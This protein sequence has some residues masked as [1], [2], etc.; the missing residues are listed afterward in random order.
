M[1]TK[2]DRIEDD[3]MN[4]PDLQDHCRKLML[5]L[6]LA[7]FAV[8]AQAGE[9][10]PKPASAATIAAQTQAR[11]T[12]PEDSR[13]D[14]E[15]VQRGFIATPAERE[16]RRADGH[17]V[18]H[19]GSLE[20]VKGDAPPS[21]NPSLW[22]QAKLLGSHGLYKVTEGVW[23]VRGID[24]ANMMIVSG[25]TGWI[26]IDPLM[27]TETASVAMK[28]VNE[29]LGQRPVSAVIYG[30]SHPDH[31]GGVRAVITPGTHP[32]IYAPEHLITEAVAENVIAGNAMARR[33]GYQFGISLKAGP[34]GYVNSGIV[35]A[36]ANG[37]TVTIIPP[38]DSIKA[39]GE[40][41]VIDG[42]NF[43]FQVVPETEAPSEM[44]FYLPQLNT[45]YVSEDT[46]CTMHNV[47]TPRGALVRD[48]NKW[49]WYITE[50]LNLYGDRVENLVTGHCWPRFGND[51]I[52]NYLALQRD[53]Y[54]F[55]HDQT[56]RLM[57]RGETPTEIAE[58][59]KVPAAISNQWSNHG[60]YGTVKHNAKGVFQR[61]IGW[62]DGIPAHLDQ[63]PTTELST[64]YVKAMGGAQ[65]VLREA[66]AAMK[67]GEYRWAA[68]ILS[69]LVFAAPDNKQAKAL[70]AD[71]YEQ[72]GYQQESAI[73]RNIYLTGADEL[74]GTA[75]SHMALASPDMVDAMPASAFLDLIATRLNPA[76]IGTRTMT[77]VVDYG[78][79]GDT[80]LVTLRNAVLVS[81]VGKSI[82]APTVSVSGPRM[83]L[84]GLFVRKLPLDKMETAGLKV[85]GDKAALQVL[86]DAIEP[87]PTDYLIVTP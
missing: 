1:A 78:G 67:R 30:H 17:V 32:P 10:A 81:E 33:T 34:R 63:L 37:G 56:V 76:R 68:Q 16:I 11:M 41:R 54:K 18:W 12:L 13:Q 22:R 86:L 65:G 75:P 31:F 69:D 38:T 66:K 29:N 85:S 47:Q 71:S 72:L 61:Y 24:A 45:L 44:N 21:V 9:A 70:L 53:N 23:Q 2:P 20:W 43:E 26:V 15:F 62:W 52:K 50:A 49:A 74:R 87:P 7:V 3:K 59:L 42:V 6:A 8:G 57:N 60:Y 77:L 27:T 82:A 64:H 25:K 80:S 36:A 83:L 73:W 79:T 84:A 58:Q 51:A 39:T 48:A 40:T 46:T 4:T 55:I 5:T 14:D 35:E 19:I 28:L